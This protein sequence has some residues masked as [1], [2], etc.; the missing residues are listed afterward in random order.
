VLPGTPNT[1]AF[2]DLRKLY[3]AKEGPRYVRGHAVTMAM[4]AW[5]CLCYAFMWFYFARVNAQRAKGDEDH[6]VHGM[7]DE[8]IAELGDDSPRFVYT[9]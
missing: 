6:G 9:I 3:P 1:L 4:V 2:S 5:A 8:E 7:T